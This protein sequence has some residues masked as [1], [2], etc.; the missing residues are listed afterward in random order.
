MRFAER[1]QPGAYD[2]AFADPPYAAD[3]AARLVTLFRASPFAGVLAVEHA[4][5]QP[6]S[7][8]DTRKYGDTAI[9]FV[10]GS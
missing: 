3:A 8:D 10:Y 6:L 2:V 1:L 9:T 7:G 5:D 4:A